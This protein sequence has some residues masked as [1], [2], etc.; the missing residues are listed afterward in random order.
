MIA[1]FCMSLSV[2]PAFGQEETEDELRKKSQNPVGSLISV[3][4]KFSIDHGASDGSALIL[5]VMPVIPVKLG[6][7]NLI[8]RVIVPIIHTGGTTSG[9][10]S[11][12]G[13]GQNKGSST[14]GL[15]DI[16][17][18]G[19]FSPAEAGKV[20]W[21]VGPSLSLPTGSNPTLGSKKWS[22]G[23][24]VV[25]LTQPKPWTL[26]LITRQL[27]S[28]AGDPGRDEVSQFLLEPFINYNLDDG[29]FLITDMVM[30]ANWRKKSKDQWTIPVGGGFG[31]IF[32]IGEQAI[33]SRVELYNN[34]VRPSGA[35]TWILYFTVAFLF[36]K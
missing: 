6:K 22:A 13:G 18:T 2:I 9:N 21:G 33:N 20:I 7:W 30:T 27:W 19:F 31:R 25:L 36:P 1:F 5:N 29:W 11:I 14:T 23:P 17:Y 10:S 26:G 28:F 8:N 24:S 4:F 32:N 12:I 34:I 16:N 3:P 35:P 15:G